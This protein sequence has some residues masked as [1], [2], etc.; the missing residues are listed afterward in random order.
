MRFG[1]CLAIAAVMLAGCASVPAARSVQPLIL[2]SYNIRIDVDGDNPRW[3]ERREPL[4][5]QIAFVAP[6]IF[7]V[8]EATL[9]NADYLASQL[10][11]YDHYGLGR[12]DGDQKGESTSLFW[13]RDRFDVIDRHTEWC[14]ATPDRPSLYPGAGWPRTIT[15]VVLKDRSSGR[16]LDVRNVHFDNVSEDARR[17]CALQ[18]EHLP[19]VAGAAVIV[20]GDLNSAPDTAAYQTITASGDLVDARTI[21]RVDFGPVSTFNAF[22]TRTDSGQAIDHIFVPKGTTVTR[23]GVLT[24]SLYG[25]AISDHYPVVATLDL[26]SSDN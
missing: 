9:P 6:D 12:D 7:G 10:P 24:D 17:A 13:R 21:A 3:A 23:Y 5:R 26:K 19:P 8:Q 4:A 16:V 14:S 15:R 18:V 20:M 1:A 11:G 22:D 25:R 2:L